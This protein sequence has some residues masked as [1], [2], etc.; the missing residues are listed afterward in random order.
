MAGAISRGHNH[1]TWATSRSKASNAP[2]CGAIA[3]AGKSI[4]ESA[5]RTPGAKGSTHSD[6]ATLP[7][8]GTRSITIASRTATS[9]SPAANL[10]MSASVGSWPLAA[11]PNATRHASRRCWRQ[12]TMSFSLADHDLSRARC[13]LR[14]RSAGP[15]ARP[16]AP[17]GRAAKARATTSGGGGLTRPTSGQHRGSTHSGDRYRPWATAHAS[18]TSI[19]SASACRAAT[20]AQPPLVVISPP[21]PTRMARPAPNTLN[22]VVG[23]WG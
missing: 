1:V 20:T 2:D 6:S 10:P 21:N 11:S 12:R 4:T 19:C 23:G 9:R 13:A 18:T 8:P 3:D 7:S 16:G 14:L 17:W 15:L 5:S 22:L